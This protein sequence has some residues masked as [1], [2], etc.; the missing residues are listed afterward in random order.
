MD[1]F[2]QIMPKVFV[3]VASL[4]LIGLAASLLA[5][6]PALKGAELM[7]GIVGAAYGFEKVKE[8]VGKLPGLK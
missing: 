2:K 3:N 1:K 4:L 7:F 5:L 6:I 8:L